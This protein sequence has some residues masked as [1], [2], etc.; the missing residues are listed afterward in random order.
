MKSITENFKTNILNLQ[1]QKKE[2]VANFI[3]NKKNI[4]LLFLLSFCCLFLD[5]L[6]K[7]IALKTLIK[8]PSNSIEVF[9]FFNFSLVH[10]KG[11]SFGLF[12]GLPFAKE[13][14]S[15]IVIAITLFL[16]FLLLKEK[17]AEL[18]CA[19]SLIISGA[20][21]NTV[22]R[23]TYGGVIDFLD[24]HIADIH[25]PAFNVADTVIFIGVAILISADFILGICSKNSRLNGKVGEKNNI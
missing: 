22:D 6:T 21:G 9:S 24:F 16:I 20:I 17:R 5:Q 8:I 25:Y 13:I 15:C 3:E 23:I 12:S 18:R 1:K 4:F 19:Y 14:I 10:N 7:Q 2:L 11:V